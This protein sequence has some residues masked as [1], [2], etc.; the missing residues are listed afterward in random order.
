MDVQEK[1]CD[2]K[3]LLRSLG[4]NS[5]EREHH[6]TAMLFKIDFIYI[7]GYACISLK[8]LMHLFVHFQV[9]TVVLSKF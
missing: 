7:Q 9:T 5:S 1:I 6:T 3:Q 8:W 4:V 2:Q